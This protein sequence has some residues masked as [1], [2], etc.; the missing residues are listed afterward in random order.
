MNIFFLRTRP[1]DALEKNVVIIYSNGDRFEGQI[2]DQKRENNG[3][4]FYQNGDVYFGEWRADSKEGFGILQY[5][6]GDKFVGFFANNKKNGFGEYFYTNGSFYQGFWSQNIKNGFGIIFHKNKDQFRGIFKNNKKD[7]KGFFLTKDGKIFFQVWNMDNFITQ[8]QIDAKTMDLSEFDY[9][10]KFKEFASKKDE[11][12]LAN[13]EERMGKT[14]VK[15]NPDVQETQK[16]DSFEGFNNNL[17][18]NLSSGA[19]ICSFSYRASR[20]FDSMSLFDYTDQLK[21]MFSEKDL[22]NAKDWSQEQVQGFLSKIGMNEYQDTFEKNKINGQVLLKMREIDFRYLGIKAK[23]DLIK[24]IDFVD[25]LKIL[26]NQDEYRQ[27]LLNKKLIPES[28]VSEKLISRYDIENEKMIEEK[29]WESSESDT[30]RQKY[31]NR[32]NEYY[33]QNDGKNQHNKHESMEETIKRGSSKYDTLLQFQQHF[34]NRPSKKKDNQL[35]SNGKNLVYDAF[36]QHLKRT[37]SFTIDYDNPV[38]ENDQINKVGDDKTS[39]PFLFNRNESSR[40]VSHKPGKFASLSS[41]SEEFGNFEKD[42]KDFKFLK[43]KGDYREISEKDTQEKEFKLVKK[44]SKKFDHN[45]TSSLNSLSAKYIINRNMLTLTEKLQEGAFGMV[46]KG[47]YLHQVVAV[48]VYKKLNNTRFHVKSFLKEVEILSNLRHPD[49]LLY[50]G[51]CVDGD[52]CFMISEYLENGSLFDHLH[53]KKR[54]EKLTNEIIFEI[55]KGILRALQYIHSKGIVHCDLKSSNILID[56][57]WSIKLADFGLSKK[58][59]GVNILDK[60]R[61][62]RVGT[63][64]WMAP[65]ICRGENYTDKADVYSFGLIVWEIVTNQV[66]YR[67]MNANQIISLVGQS[68][69]QPVRLL[70]ED[71]RRM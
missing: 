66:P 43:E 36:D 19:K 30:S 50:M 3:W 22:K 46:Y 67:E 70:V 55:L 47:T 51:V 38:E 59:I 4:Y 39:S 31:R 53:G 15:L 16:I 27:K 25:K 63:P 8:K 45:K 69:T 23:G 34:S 56:D 10:K 14:C 5:K 42:A 61:Q 64:N 58:M 26:C 21:S 54:K 24:L 7:G 11:R 49:I 44:K 60:N 12:I 62:S 68:K 13:F 41:D 65:E 2:K 18:E 33:K 28:L 17:N 40:N 52:D 57:S 35:E 71:S 37:Q 9:D 29:S 32:K 6:S 1:P 48:K 20:N